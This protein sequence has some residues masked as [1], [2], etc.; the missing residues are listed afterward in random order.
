[1]FCFFS[2]FLL[3][4]ISLLNADE[5]PASKAPT[6]TTI[7]MAKITVY[8]LLSVFTAIIY[9]V[10]VT[11]FKRF[12]RRDTLA[13]TTKWSIVGASTFINRIASITPSG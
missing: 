12:L 1:M 2:N 6:I 7:I 3:L 13:C 8:E 4:L 9:A 11:V 10:L 5:I